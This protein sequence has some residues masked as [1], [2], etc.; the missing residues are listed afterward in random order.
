MPPMPW[1]KKR[2]ARPGLQE[3]KRQF[4]AGGGV[5]APPEEAPADE[6]PETQAPAELDPK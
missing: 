4:V 3:K 5:S 1:D 2:L 6:A